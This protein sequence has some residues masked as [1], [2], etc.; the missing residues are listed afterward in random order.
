[1]PACPARPAGWL[2]SPRI[3]GQQA[4]D[5][6]G[7]DAARGSRIEDEDRVVGPDKGDASFQQGCPRGTQ[8]V[9]AQRHQVGLRSVIW[10]AHSAALCPGSA[11]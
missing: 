6:G 8:V 1:M 4:V 10:P 5:D 3:A 7:L 2:L 9:Y 11:A